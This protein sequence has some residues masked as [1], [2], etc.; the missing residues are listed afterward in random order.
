M[1]KPH[2]LSTKPSVRERAVNSGR[3]GAR[4]ADGKDRDATKQTIAS[5]G[6]KEAALLPLVGGSSVDEVELRFQLRN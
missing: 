6:M 2:R 3:C 4:A 1:E 5:Y